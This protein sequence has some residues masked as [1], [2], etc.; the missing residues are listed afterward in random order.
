MIYRGKE[1][2]TYP[3]IIDYALSLKGKKQ[4]AFVRAYLK[5]GPH[6]ASNIGYFAGYYDHKKAQKDRKS[7]RLNSSHT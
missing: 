5:T 1:Y 3:E 7:T 4:T 2:K 6:A